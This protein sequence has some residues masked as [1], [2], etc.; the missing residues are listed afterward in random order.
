M[1]SFLLSLSLVDLQQRHWRLSQ[2]SSTDPESTWSRFTSWLAPEPY[3]WKHDSDPTAQNADTFSGFYTRK[4]HRAMAKM[5]I[6]DAFDMRRR[7]LFAF[8][9]WAV[10]GFV[11]LVYAT[12]RMYGWLSRA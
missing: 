12:R 6:S 11:A 9:A 1:I 3:T 7:V 8:A 10:L 4:K 5:E 2:H